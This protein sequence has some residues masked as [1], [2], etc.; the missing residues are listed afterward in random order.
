MPY[1]FEQN[2][3]AERFN[4]TIIIITKCILQKTELLN[5]FWAEASSYSNHLKN[6]LL[7]IEKASLFKQINKKKPLLDVKRTF[8]SLCKMHIPKEYRTKLDFI[9]INGIYLRTYL[10]TQYKVY[11]PKCR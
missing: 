3:T 9:A 2:N 5:G 1:T 6:L 10:I 11:I 4:K 7:M 8:G